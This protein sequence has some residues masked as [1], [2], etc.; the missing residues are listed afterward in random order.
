MR[1]ET[2]IRDIGMAK[3]AKLRPEFSSLQ[4][5]DKG[6]EDINGFVHVV[7]GKVICFN[8]DVIDL[9]DEKDRADLM[10]FARHLYVDQDLLPRYGE[11]TVCILVPSDRASEHG[12]VCQESIKSLPSDMQETIR[13]AHH[14][15]YK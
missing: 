9:L 14:G 3:I 12:L 10:D 4:A 15:Y 1:A 7:C 6:I 13:R 2:W 11:N 5:E 8:N